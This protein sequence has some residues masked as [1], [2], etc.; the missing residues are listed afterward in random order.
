M[1]NI[2]VVDDQQQI[3]DFLREILASEGFEVLTASNG[4]DALQLYQEHRPAFTLTDISMPQMNGIELLKQIK[5]LNAEAVVMLMT[6]DGAETWAIE[7]L[8]GGA[9][10]Y[11][12]KPVDIKEL[13]NTVQRYASLAAGYDFELFATDFM[14]EEQIHLELQNDLGQI[15]H[16][17]QL[18]VNRCRSIF[19][20]SDIFLLR[21]GIYEMLINAVE[22][23]NLGI[24]YEEKTRALEENRLNEL[25]HERAAMPDLARRR[26]HVGCSITPAGLVCTI[27]DEGAG[28]DHSIY[29]SVQDPGQLFEELGTSLHGRGIMLTC[30]QF[31]KVEFN[32]IG[33]TVRI[34]K[35]APGASSFADRAGSAAPGAGVQ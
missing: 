24:N 28:F 3:L 22:H 13:L 32:E 35:R 16:A 21:F 2:L 5:A 9:V 17:V 26:V 29:S 31:D 8:R 19:P 23:G 15:N 12:N 1:V 27:R 14:R 30:L 6:G 20:L 4:V 7:A 10:N 25:I 34:E 11:F 18:I 33:N